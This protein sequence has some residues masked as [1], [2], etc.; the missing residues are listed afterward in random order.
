MGC[1]YLEK[2]N[3][4]EAVRSFEKAIAIEPS[5]Y[6]KAADNLKK[7]KM[8]AGSNN[9]GKVQGS[10]FRVQGAIGKGSGFGFRVC[11]LRFTTHGSRGRRLGVC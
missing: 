8:M 11:G 1:I 2:G 9:R 6:A 5:Y 10:G 3:Y 4:P 7:A